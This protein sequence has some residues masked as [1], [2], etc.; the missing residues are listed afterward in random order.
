MKR[1][2]TKLDF[3]SI[4]DFIEHLSNCFSIKGFKVNRIFD[5]KWNWYKWRLVI[6]Y[7]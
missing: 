5:K 2:I 7:E 6:E 3:S 4:M 1:Q